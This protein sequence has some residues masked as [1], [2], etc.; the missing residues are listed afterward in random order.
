MSCEGRAQD[1]GT[2]PLPNRHCPLCGGPNGCAPAT[3]GRFDV[4]CWCRDARFTPALL[5]QVA[6]AQRG[7]ACVCAACAARGGPPGPGTP[8]A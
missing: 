5:A 4:D 1:A 2:A 3:C 8:A 6:P 7:Q